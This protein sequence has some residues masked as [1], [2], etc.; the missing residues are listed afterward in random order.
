MQFLSLYSGEYHEF[1]L[2]K[3]GIGLLVPQ[4]KECLDITL[5]LEVL[6]E[7]FIP[8]KEF[9][10]I[11]RH[12]KDK[13]RP[14]YVM[15]KVYKDGSFKVKLVPLLGSH[16]NR[17]HQLEQ[18]GHWAAYSINN[19]L[20]EA[21]VRHLVELIYNRKYV[22]RTDYKSIFMKEFKERKDI[23]Q[24][25]EVNIWSGKFPYSF[26]S[27][28]LKQWIDRWIKKKTM[29]EKQWYLDSEHYP[30]FYTKRYKPYIN[31]LDIYLKGDPNNK[32][33]ERQKEFW[34]WYYEVY[35]NDNTYPF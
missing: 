12:H 21:R 19:D 13:D 25:K 32:L 4:Q 7:R 33:N 8:D 27:N 11:S 34:K 26:D 23:I 10:G 18:S 15:F 28:L 20:A 9:I 2:E 22:P 31:Q 24:G 30:E 35:P 17:I 1:F 14:Y 5:G 6:Q 3:S 29:T 16:W